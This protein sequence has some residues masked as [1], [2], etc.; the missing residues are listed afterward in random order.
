MRGLLLV[1]IASL[2]CDAS[3]RVEECERLQRLSCE[4]FPLCEAGDRSAISS[5]DPSACTQRLKEDFSM[6]QVC[7]SGLRQG[8]VRCDESC[9]HGWGSCAFEI[10][11]QAGLTPANVCD[12]VE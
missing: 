7:A 6:W 4:C 8:G 10:Y 9:T 5:A 1:L 2:A 3:T 12:K 11:R